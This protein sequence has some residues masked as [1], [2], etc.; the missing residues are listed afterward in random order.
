[1]PLAFA[2][3]NSGHSK[4]LRQANHVTATERPEAWKTH[5]GHLGSRL[6]SRLG[7]LKVKRPSVAGKEVAEVAPREYAVTQAPL[8][9]HVGR[10]AVAHGPEGVPAPPQPPAEEDQL[11][12]AYVAA[13]RQR[14]CQRRRSGGRGSRRVAAAAAHT[15]APADTVTFVAAVCA[16]V[17]LI[18]ARAKGVLGL[19]RGEAAE[20]GVDRPHPVADLTRHKGPPRRLEGAHCRR[21]RPTAT[22]AGVTLQ[23][24]DSPAFGASGGA[25]GWRGALPELDG[26][27]GKIEARVG[28][29][30]LHQVEV[31]AQAQGI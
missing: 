11:H 9:V 21:R 3:C 10:V 16:G 28:R 13:E 20:A 7:N 26:Y 25:D 12:R 5:G 23:T 8:V 27:E 1:M 22:V 4:Q 19:P 14:R 31:P 15:R 2:I 30:S 18:V 6:G 29:S 17:L 24:C